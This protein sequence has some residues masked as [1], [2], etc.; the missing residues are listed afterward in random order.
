[1]E[2]S[3]KDTKTVSVSCELWTKRAPEEGR[4][5]SKEH[6]RSALTIAGN[7]LAIASHLLGLKDRFPDLNTYP[8]CRHLLN[9]LGFVHEGL[10]RWGV[11]SDQAPGQEED[12]A[13][14]AERLERL[15]QSL[16][17]VDSKLELGRDSWD[18]P[19]VSAIWLLI[20]LV[21]KKEET[22]P[23]TIGEEQRFNVNQ[24]SAL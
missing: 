23:T 14:L 11:Q 17:G 8:T 24:N 13:E 10:A 21:Y 3:S 12:Q 22:T 16:L 18:V 6:F 5:R 20:E 2:K 19:S 7:M 4:R 15:K 1:M 9:L